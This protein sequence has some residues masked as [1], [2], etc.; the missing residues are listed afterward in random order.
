MRLIDTTR[1]GDGIWKGR[2][3]EREPRDG[4]PP[5]QVIAT[6]F[7]LNVV[8]V[9]RT[10][11]ASVLLPQGLEPGQR[12]TG[13]VGFYR[14][15][16]GLTATSYDGGFVALE[17][18]G[19]D[20]P[21]ETTVFMKVANWYT[22]RASDVMQAHFDANSAPGEIRS[23]HEGDV[24]GAKGGPVGSPAISVRLRRRAQ[25]APLTSGTHYFVGALGTNE[26][27]F[28]SISFAQRFVEA[29][30]LRLEVLGGAPP[31][32]KAMSPRSSFCYYSPE[33]FLTFS[34]PQP[35]GR[36]ADAAPPDAAR[37]MLLDIF[38]RL[39]RAAAIV[40]VGGRVLYLNRK[41][42]ALEGQGF[43]VTGRHLRAARTVDQPALCAAIER[44][45]TGE[46]MAEPVLLHGGPSPIPLLVRAMPM[47]AAAG[48]ETSVLLLFTSPSDDGGADVAKMLK[49][50]GLSPAEAKVAML[51]GTGLSPR[52]A[53]AALG[54]AES[55]VR[56]ALKAIYDKLAINRQSELAQ[57][58][59][60]LN[61]L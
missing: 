24:W 18:E 61:A 16:C 38:L 5:F 43:M 27:S 33:A 4:G 58:V 11:A 36:T 41:A 32:L 26:F 34:R 50:L 22:G 3:P 21:A 53:A 46:P 2:L 57:M 25:D 60:R 10:A 6:D 30:C 28:Y 15:Q 40:G 13:L 31:I 9:D 39:G 55:T 49:V 17:I 52:D 59:A 45:A 37:M 1:R 19:H 44:A 20:A 42:Q 56:S 23:W 51:V 29:D 54:V 47:D 35:L 12:P 48:G 14:A 8:D 7:L